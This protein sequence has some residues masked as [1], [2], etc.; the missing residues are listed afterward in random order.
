M[1]VIRLRLKRVDLDEP[2]CGLSCEF[3]VAEK[4][5]VEGVNDVVRRGYNL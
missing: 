2:T 4:C 1:N 5:F 3:E